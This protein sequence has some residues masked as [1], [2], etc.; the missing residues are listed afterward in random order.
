[1]SWAPPQNVGDKDP[2][3]AAAKVKLRKYSYGHGLG[4]SGST[5][6]TSV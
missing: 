3:I 2:S 5:P 6:T 1:M 4:T